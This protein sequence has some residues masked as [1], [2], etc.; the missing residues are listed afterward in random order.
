MLDNWRKCYPLKLEL[1]SL[2]LV[3]LISYIVLWNY[4]ELP[5]TIPIHFDAVGN[6]DGFGGK[7]WIILILIISVSNFLGITLINFLFAVVEDPRRFINLPGRS[8]MEAMT[9]EQGEAV[10]V[11]MNRSIFALKIVTLSLETYLAWQ[12]VEIGLGRS[13]SM[14][15]WIWFFA[16]ALVVI[17]VY[18][19][20]KG[21]RLTKTAN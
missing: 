13:S 2:S 8:A 7:G 12:M 5:D 19:I 21:I 6:P 9:R 4:A 10:R 15:L 14:G 20:W 3:F 18:M 11:S 1:L 17:V 16:G